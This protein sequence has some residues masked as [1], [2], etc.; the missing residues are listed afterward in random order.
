MLRFI[1]SRIAWFVPNTLLLT[2]LL[3]AVLTSWVGSPAAMMLGDAAT[4]E[5]LAEMERAYGFDDPVVVQYGRWLFNAI[6][7]DFGRSYA[8]K[9]E[10]VSMIVGALPITIELSFWAILV[11]GIAAVTLSSITVGSRYI[12]VVVTIIAVIGISVPN[13]M[14]GTSLDYLFAIQLR[15]L[16]TSGWVAW[17]ESISSHFRHLILP[18][19]TLCLFYFGSFT[20]VY[21]AE[22]RNIT[23]Q[24]FVLVAKAKGISNSRVSMLHVLPNSALPIITYIGI[25]LGQLAGGAVVTEVV[26]SLPGVGRV[27]V[28]AIKGNDFP[29]ILAIGMM[30][31]TA[32]MFFNLLADIVLA[33]INPQV[34]LWK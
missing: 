20:M 11:A 32:M 15:W 31:L 3:F 19:V 14:L 4:Q 33:W 23:R 22:Y 29:V 16:P 27:F 18:V 5:S 30:V 28:A 9:Q 2:F 34:R 17:S 26:F 8:T 12:T 7:G 10:V 1:L 21:R 24:L 6:Q 13:F 25:S